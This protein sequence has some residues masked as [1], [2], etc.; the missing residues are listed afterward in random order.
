[1]LLSFFLCILGFV[2][3][4]YAA[5]KLVESATNLALDLGVSKM[6]VGLTIVAAGTSLP[7]LVVSMNASLKGNSALSLGNVIGSN[8]MNT[9]LILGVA[10]LICPISCEK[11]MVKREVPVMIGVSAILWYLAYT[12]NV[13]TPKEGLLLV[14]LFFL[15][16]T[17]SYII[18]RREAAIAKEIQEMSS[19]IIGEISSD[20]QQ[21]TFAQNI[22]YIVVGFI[23]LVIG[24]EL[25]VR[26]SV[27]I[28]Q[29]LGVSDEVIGLTLIAI[30]TSLPELATSV[31]A[32]R[33][34]QSDI[35]LGNVVGSN[36]FNA[37]GIV[38]CASLTPGIADTALLSVSPNMIG[39]H[40]PLMMVVA[41]AILPIMRSDMKIVRLEGAFLVA[42]YIAYSVILFQS[43]GSESS[44]QINQQDT[45]VSINETINSSPNPQ[46]KLKDN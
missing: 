42:I 20:D 30:G 2:F 36:I 23:G 13:I 11:Q 38:G 25:L 9:A 37:L 18:G 46:P 1:M 24:A 44:A 14:T 6:V 26:G 7:E 43:S 40:I 39:I 29:G 3:L 41:L 34:G 17:M 12:G 8:I 5:D 35:A 22:G 21:L 15:Y 32:A 28:A 27:T 33:K 19:D 16:T 45:P 4:T 10:S 31:V